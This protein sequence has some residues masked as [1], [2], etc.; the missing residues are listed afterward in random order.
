MG[1]GHVATLPESRA[2]E[3]AG[4]HALGRRG[5]VLGCVELGHAVETGTR[6][7]LMVA[8]NG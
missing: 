4:G 8:D 5:A 3:G 6:E 2:A 7:M 1:P